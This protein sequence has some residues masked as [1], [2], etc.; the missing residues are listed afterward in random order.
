MARSLLVV[1]FSLSGV[2][3]LLYQFVWIR[4]LSHL[5]GGTS[6]AISTVLAAFM[7]G[8]ALGSRFFGDRT[9][10]A[11]RPLR[12][13][14]FLELGIAGL[15]A[16]VL[17]ALLAI[18]PIYAA[19]AGP[20]P[21]AALPLLRIAVA[22][23]VVL[24]P[25]FLMGG[26][27]PVLGRVLVT[28]RDRLGRGLGLLY[29]A[30]TAGA[31]LGA[32]LAGFVLVEGIGLVGCTVVAA[33]G[34]VVIGLGALAI[35][36]AGGGASAG[37]S[38]GE[39]AATPSRPEAKGADP[40]GASELD[41]RLLAWVFALSGFAA[42][43]YEIH[44]TR[45][46][47]HFL[48]NSTYA[49]SAMLTTFLFGLSAGGWVGGRLA[50]AGPH[51][52]RWLGRAQLAVGVTVALTVPAIWNVLPRLAGDAFLLPERVGWTT[53]LAR[54]FLVAFGV[55]ALPTF[56]LGTTFPLVSRLGI[57]EM[58]RLG[59]GVGV[60]YFA[61]T[62]GAIVGS[63]AAGFLILPL[64]GPKGGLLATALVSASLG[65]IVLLARRGATSAER[66]GAILVVA[67]LA[68][69]AWPLAKA[70]GSL[71]ADTQVPGDRVLLDREDPIAATR[72]YVKP[73]GEMHI[74][75]DG[76]RIGGTSE[77]LL[78][79]EK[80]LA[81]LPMVLVDDPREVLAV[82]LGSGIT[83]GSL[84]MHDE[85]EQLT[86]V[87]IVPS[88]VD[89]ARLFRAHNRDVLDDPRLELVLEDG[90]Q[91]LLT[92][93]RTFDVISSDSKLNPHYVGN[94]PLLAEDYYALCREHLESDGVLVQWL[95][96]H[97][98]APVM[99]M[100]LKS[101]AEAFEHHAIFWHYPYNLIQIGSPSPIEVRL[102]RVRELAAR[103]GVGE[104]L[105]SLQLQDP[106]AL[107]SLLI[108]ADER[109][110][111]ALA[112]APVNRWIRPRL[113]F[114]VI[115]EHLRKPVPAHED[116]N[117]LWLYRCRDFRGPRLTG[118]VDRARLDRFLF[119]SGKL[120]EGY[121]AGGGIGDLRSG[122]GAFAEGL[123]ENPDDWR[124]ERILQVLDAQA[125][126]L[127]PPS[128]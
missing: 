3:A 87:E 60:L 127:P 78:R 55:M 37:E 31:V 123:R 11:A 111:A 106:E 46:L 115:R 33:L 63:L 82:G 98:P 29:A 101:F 92:T 104:E 24:P 108:A 58:K 22:A 77:G 119:S 76:H 15:G 26:T 10:G 35:E 91:F 1:L 89:G 25:T 49:Y 19:A 47:Q 90:V 40:A 122:R 125:G 97:L 66:S 79:K 81:H 74:A 117:L 45:S 109:V 75:V 68:L 62:L 27:L 61:N 112:D 126:Q 12:I 96:M 32:F 41:G 44:W 51:R 67:L 50:D 64:L 43:G 48:G 107:A 99:R 100:V 69:A 83:L 7:G 9:D 88:V 94:A 52:A 93:D 105:Q 14:A 39:A 59:H 114:V 5:L 118:D 86:C 65:A 80:V 42:L 85:V 34:N 30:N 28:R 23:L 16:M 103:A 13:Y 72:V 84:A 56:L 21:D 20:M 73:G 116:D 4:Q 102:D 17:P 113:E 53:F 38:A 95:P 128:R 2:S 57:R 110:E 120:L 70:G 18:R 54:R 6:L 121:A 8:L 36:R 71:L 124:L